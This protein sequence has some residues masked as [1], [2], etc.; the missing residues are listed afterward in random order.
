M[1][2]PKG[3]GGLGRGLSALIPQA[4]EIES[5]FAA[6]GSEQKVSLELVSINPYQPRRVFDEDKL[7]ELTESIKEHGVVQP[8]LVRPFGDGYQLVAGERRLRAARQAGLAE[9]PALVREMTDHEMMEIALIENIQRQDLDP[10]EE[11]RAYKRL[12]E[13]FNQTQEQIA[14]RV[15]KSRSYIANSMRLLNLPES[16]LKY[17][18]GG[19][20][21]IGHV[22]PLLMLEEKEAVALAQRLIEEKATARE[23]E[24]WAKQ[25]L[26]PEL[27]IPQPQEPAAFPASV[28]KSSSDA[29]EE[30]EDEE[31]AGGD[32]EDAGRKGRRPVKE[33]LSIELKEIQ[34]ILRDKVNTKVEIIQGTK[35]GKIV[36]D[37][38]TQDDIERILEL[39]AGSSEI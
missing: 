30:T 10:V 11:A 5:S 35:G 18:A 9:V 1:A 29:N 37:Y 36:I 20:L 23:A 28:D 17:L 14:K 34:H 33:P 15:S 25:I 7:R 13:E 38:Y 39:F 21:T 2:K 31:E 24:L 6:A 27:S 3:M 8:I 4:E 16:I 19:A 12:S 22:R 32:K 26:N